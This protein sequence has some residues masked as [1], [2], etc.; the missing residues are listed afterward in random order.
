MKTIRIILCALVLTLL[1]T[2]CATQNPP[3][4]VS[5]DPETLQYAECGHY[6]ELY[7]ANESDFV[8][9][10][11]AVNEKKDTVD[12]IVVIRPLNEPASMYYR[13]EQEYSASSD[14]NDLASITEFF[15]LLF[16]LDGQFLCE[17]S[18]SDVMIMYD[19][20]DAQGIPGAT[21]TWRRD[22]TPEFHMNAY[23]GHGAI[24][25]RE[26]EHNGVTYLILEWMEPTTGGTAG[27]SIH[28]VVD[29]KCYNAS[30]PAGYTDEE[31]LAFCQFET[32]VV[33]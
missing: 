32:V 33:E 17:I 25:E 9:A 22:E 16:T 2:A 23:R 26:I 8:E 3:I 12:D 4:V 28:W 30:I 24:S 20:M 21:L 18:V 7:F 19:Y 27:Y 31:M 10:I 5:P 13:I 15:K 11:R 29:G 6:P 1:T 14:V